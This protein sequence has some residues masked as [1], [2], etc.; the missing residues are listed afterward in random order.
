MKNPLI[1]PLVL[2]L[3]TAAPMISLADIF[4][5]DTFTNGSNLTNASPANPTT[6][7]TS[8]QLVSSKSWSP[9]PSLT[10]GDLK[11]GIAK[12]SSGSIEAQARFATI[13]VTLINPGDYI[14]LTVTFT[15]TVGLMTNAGTA[16]GFGL[17]NSGGT[18]PA[19]GGLNGSAT[20]STNTT[21]GAQHWLGYV[22]QVNNIASG[23]TRIMTRPDQTE[24]TGNNQDVVTSNSGS[25]SYA[26]SATVGA[27]VTNSLTLTAGSTYTEDLV[28]SLS[29]VNTL[30][31]TNS[32][33]AGVDTNGTLLVQVGGTTNA[34]FLTAG[35]D[36]FAIGWRY[37]ANTGPTTIDISSIQIL[38]HGTVVTAPPDIVTQPASASVP[39]GG[40]CDFT[41][42]ANGYT[43]TYQ[44]HRNG[45]NLINGGNIS[46]ANSSM[47]VVSP[48]SAADVSSTY[49]VT[50][51]GAGGFSTNS[52]NASLS[53]RTTAN[54]IWSG[55]GSV[56]DLNTTAAWL[57]GSTPSVFNFGDNVTFDDTGIANGAVS[58]AGNF[59]SAGTVTVNA[60]L[61][62]DYV[63][64]GSGNFAGP[65]RLLYI[66]GGHLSL[67]NANSYSGG[68]LISNTTAYLVLNNYNGLGTG[69]VTLG[70]A[71][72]QM[73]LA[74]SGNA[75]TGINGD[76]IVQDDFTIM[77]DANSA[78]GAVFLGNLAGTPGKTLTLT[79]NNSSPTTS[80]VRVYGGNTHFAANI[81]INNP[82]TT[83]ASY[84]T[85]GTQTYDG[86]ISGTGA[87]MQKGTT[88]YLNAAN[89]Y[90]GATIPATGAIGLGTNSVGSTPDSGPIGTGPLYLTIDSTSGTT[91]NGMLFA[92]GGPRTIAN[93][94]QYP[95]A[96]NN[97]TLVLGGTNALTFTG[98]I[99][100]NGNDANGTN[101]IRIFQ[102]TNEAL[103][104]FSG[105]IS[106][107]GAGFGLV[108][109]GNGIL[110]L[111]NIETYSGPTT[112]SNGTL[113]LNGQLAGGAVAVATNSVL[114]GTGSIGG[115]VT[116]QPGGAIAP[117]DSIGTLTI[118]ND[119]TIA[120]NLTIEVNKSAS[121]A[122]DQIVVSGALNNSGTGTVTVT[123][124][125]PALAKNDSF[126]LF[127]KPLTNG[128]AMTVTGGG[129]GIT[130]T[131]K[132][133]IDGSI[134]VL[135]VA[136]T[137]PTNL[138][139]SI[140][141]GNIVLSWPTGYTGWTIE[142]QTNAPGKGLTTNWVRIP[143]SSG[144]NQLT[145]PI[146]QTNGSVFFRMVLP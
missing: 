67:N 100:L 66:G 20:T 34:P 25:S 135:S 31:I 83:F 137:T 136:S 140:S 88:T 44:W 41:V 106:D 16:F 105:V 99:T 94:I 109:T 110:A 1:T 143:I 79:H 19:A 18:G 116:V 117:G 87:F 30:A 81:V 55:S 27:G 142:A 141:G 145:I 92:S 101:T 132:L 125:G 133:A 50:V 43:M 123:N 112:I 95:T 4:F 35:F 58:L 26:G 15:N 70:M 128:G 122:S 45:T 52:A 108:K 102:V 7:N 138:S 46:G 42:V 24:T 130:W 146:A 11:F 48:V 63:F 113:Q 57:N 114:G 68:T 56:W 89:T 91:G 49:Y 36:A 40:A 98:P 64:S 59:L 37:N 62:N 78:F 39:V 38:G 65:G 29:D 124:L 74:N 60:S 121:P 73:E 3:L 118:N 23:T 8:Y 103:T 115:P 120:G 139:Y 86:V 71:G 144:V 111:N 127:S 47:L 76:I 2:A 53:L 12:T 72:G 9:T 129:V 75:T 69:P 104:T 13:P 96:T 32:F 77:Y 131:N 17:Y 107:S 22:G 119:L 93:S 80:R 126:T 82:E 28:I 90:S 85:S 14:E 51:N 84:Q 33:Y 21:G 61:G 134:S 97:L 6:T 54:L 10:S 5:S